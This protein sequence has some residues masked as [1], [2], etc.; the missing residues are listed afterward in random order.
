MNIG[1]TAPAGLIQYD[2]KRTTTDKLEEVL[3]AYDGWDVMQITHVGGRDWLVIAK[4]EWESEL[5]RDAE[6]EG[7]T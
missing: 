7:A 3:N 6:L 5:D 1:M 4:Y 2:V